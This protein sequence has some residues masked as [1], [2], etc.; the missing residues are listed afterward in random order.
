MAVR[1]SLFAHGVGQTAM[2]Y[3]GSMLV[4]LNFEMGVYFC[5]IHKIN[6]ISKKRKGKGK[7]G[8]RARQ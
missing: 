8:S 6:K 7:D 1:V 3:G 5:K 2:G 4:L